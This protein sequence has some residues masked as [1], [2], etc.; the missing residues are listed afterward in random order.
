MP[1]G[2]SNVLDVAKLSFSNG[3]S[4]EKSNVNL[5][6]QKNA[7]QRS[8]SCPPTL[9]A[10]MRS[11]RPKQ[12][13]LFDCLLGIFCFASDMSIMYV[14]I[15]SRNRLDKEGLFL[16]FCLV[17]AWMYVGKPLNINRC[18]KIYFYCVRLSYIYYVRLLF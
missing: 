15:W 17:R 5:N 18:S 14:I 7:S 6:R 13:V 3:V 16:Y 10:S 11:F 9:V 12:I 8:E 2:T 4:C 1:A